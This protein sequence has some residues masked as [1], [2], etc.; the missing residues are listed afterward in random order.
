MQRRSTRARLRG[1]VSSQMLVRFATKPLVS[2]SCA[3][4]FALPMQC[5]LALPQPAS[6]QKTTTNPNQLATGDQ[7]EKTK[8][9]IREVARIKLVMIRTL[10]PNRGSR[11]LKLLCFRFGCRRVLCTEAGGLAAVNP[12]G[13]EAAA[14]HGRTARRPAHTG[15]AGARS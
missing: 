2:S 12:A 7:P 10:P 13:A 5:R 9:R 4:F 15:E 1:L 11:F 6:F 14:V 3:E 8:P